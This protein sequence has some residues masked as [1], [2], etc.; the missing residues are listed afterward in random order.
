[1]YACQHMFLLKH[2]KHLNYFFKIIH[3]SGKSTDIIQ[4]IKIMKH[5]NDYIIAHLFRILK[6]TCHRSSHLLYSPEDDTKYEL[7]VREPTAQPGNGI[8]S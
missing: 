5:S 2:L 8:K 3:F 6:D 4:A 7:Q 1:M